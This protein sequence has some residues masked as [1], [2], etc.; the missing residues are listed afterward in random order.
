[1]STAAEL[2]KANEMSNFKKYKAKVYEAL[3]N[4]TY[5]LTVS[6]LA[7]VCK[8]SAKTI[9]QI[10]AEL[11]VEKN[12]DV[13]LLI[14]KQTS[15][16]NEQEIIESK[17]LEESPIDIPTSIFMNTIC[18]KAAELR[19]KDPQAF[20]IF[21]YDVMRLSLSLYS[22]TTNINQFDINVKVLLSNMVNRLERYQNRLK[23]Q[24]IIVEKNTGVFP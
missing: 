11:E 1:M 13:Y 7:T 4:D 15:P 24:N 19:K 14:S 9:K 17:P 23:P 2:K 8:L 18:P 21:A 12:G 10:L 20:S 22:E 5:G 16:D 3:A 6:Q